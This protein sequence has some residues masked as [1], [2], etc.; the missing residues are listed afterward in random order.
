MVQLKNMYRYWLVVDLLPNRC[1][2]INCTN[3]YTV[4]WYIHICVTLPQYSSCCKERWSPIGHVLWW[5]LLG[6]LSWYPFIFV[7]PLQLIWRL[8]IVEFNCRYSSSNGIF[9]GLVQER[10]NSSALAMELCLSCI[11]PS[12]WLIVATKIVVPGMATRVTWAGWHT[13]LADLYMKIIEAETTWLP[14]LRQHFLSYF[15]KW[16]SLYF[17]KISLKFVPQCPI[18]NISVLVWIMA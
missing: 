6:L 4:S 17:D 2:A 1:Q 18:N 7:Q 10:R 15:L 8:G 5:Q 14:F 12:K 13:P 3:D 16:K 11:N 9:D